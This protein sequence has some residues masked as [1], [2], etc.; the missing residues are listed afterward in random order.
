LPVTDAEIPSSRD[1]PIHTHDDR[2]KQK[3]GASVV[4]VGWTDE[5]KV[6]LL[7]AVSDDVI[8][9]GIK[10]GDLIKQI[11]PIVGGGGGG[12]PNMAQAGGNDPTKLGEALTQARKL[13]ETQSTK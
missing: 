13:V 12:R 3:A 8:K 4:V 5:G 11:A 9:K 1:D 2:I 7:A 6:G 10:A